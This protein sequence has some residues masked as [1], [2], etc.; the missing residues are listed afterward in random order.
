MQDDERREAVSPLNDIPP[1]IWALVAPMAL[2]E[3]YLSVSEA[4]GMNNGL[5]QALWLKLGFF[6]EALRAGWE[7]G[8]VAPHDWLRTIS[9]PLIHGSFSHVLFVAVITLA[10]GKFIGEV[11]RWWAVLAVVLAATA[12]GALVSALLPFV[13]LGVLGGYP[14]VYGL[15]GAFTY[16]LWVGARVTGANPARAFSM[17]AFLLGAQL[18]FGLAF[19]GGTDWVA[20]IAGFVA[21]FAVSVAVSPAGW[22]KL[23]A[24]LRGR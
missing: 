5:R 18:V 20:D 19:G 3:I 1:V 10:M 16:V 22:A 8:Y 9:Y 11:F 7:Q 4:L 13:K 15:I 23:A 14:P 12:A 6:P 2:L 24:M 21:G 17:I